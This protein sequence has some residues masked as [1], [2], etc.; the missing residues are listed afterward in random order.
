[1]KIHLMIV[2]LLMTLL[3]VPASADKVSLPLEDVTTI[4]DPETSAKR[5]LFRASLD[6][7]RSVAVRRAY[8]RIPLTAGSGEARTNLWVHPL[9]QTWSRGATWNSFSQGGGTYDDSM[10]GR[11]ELAASR[12][13]DL[14]IDI[15]VM[16]KE[17][18][19]HEAAD[20]GFVLTVDPREGVGLTSDEAARLTSLTGAT[21]V[22]E[23]RPVP[24]ARV[25]RARG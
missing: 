3:A 4:T 24:T 17:I 19:E 15:T 22:V 25:E 6:L 1:M 9:T 8:V 7:E 21:L 23:F 13:E 18:L 12:Q 5:V 20:H 10:Y 16:A 11:A 2:L 14:F